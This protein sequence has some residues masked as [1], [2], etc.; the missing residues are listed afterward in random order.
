MKRS[1]VLR[2][3]LLGLLLLAGLTAASAQTTNLLANPGFENP[4]E[5]VEGGASMIAQGWTPWSLTTDQNVEPEYYLASDTVN[6]MAPPR[7]HGGDDAQQYFSFFAPHIGGVYQQVAGVAPGD[8]LS[9][10]IY[11]YIWASSGEDSNVSDGSGALTFEVGIDPTGGTDA[12][13]SAIV[14]SD[15]VVNYDQYAQYAIAAVAAAD[16]VTVFVRST[17]T[18]VAMNNTVYVDDAELVVTGTG[19][20]VVTE[21]VTDTVA[22]TEETVPVLT[23]EATAAATEIVEV[24]EAV[25]TEVAPVVTEVVVP[26]EEI[27]PVVTEEPT[28]AVVTEEPV[29]VTVEVIEPT[30]VVVTEA[31]TVEVTEA[32]T[33][34]AT[35]EILPIES[36]TDIPTEVPPTVEPPTAVPTDAG[37]TEV[38][39]EAPP[40]STP[41]PSPTLDTTVFPLTF[42]Y[43]VVRGDTVGALATRYGSTIEAIIIANQ[44]GYD[45]RI[46]ETQVLLIPVQTLPEPT[47]PPTATLI[48]SETPIASVT[49]FPTFTTPPSQSP[50]PTFT[51]VPSSTPLPPP[52]E[53][54]TLVPS[55]TE[56]PVQVLPAQGVNP[57]ATTQI[58]QTYVVQYGDSLSTIAVRFGIL[59]RDL[60][61]VNNIVNPNLVY[62]GQV[63]QIPMSGTL[64]PVP[65]TAVPSLVPTTV[66]SATAIVVVP[67]P[68]Q[69]VPNP[70]VYQVQP[71]DNLYRISIR[72]NVPIRALIEINGIADASRIF[73]GQLL[74]LP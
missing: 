11:A 40:T 30:E 7:I 37:P 39:T 29:L 68:T 4:F 70:A 53:V 14:W 27:I 58:A 26:T 62:V 66:P 9:F 73:V 21:A 13:S 74:I 61:R 57:T 1:P 28:I 38:P 49:P 12:T 56:A 6:G 23:D 69:S 8:E 3:F 50:I 67:A 17:V 55:P 47:L 24:T 10:S 54:P 63:L 71:G 33:V 41:F 31:A 46:F 59:T 35:V 44:L 72:F 51:T 19:A 16:T 65:P 34:E 45:A 22:P 15:P 60:A 36:P 32:P 48:P 20:P 52:T 25:V 64:T 18:E 2:T 43:T 42:S 5:P